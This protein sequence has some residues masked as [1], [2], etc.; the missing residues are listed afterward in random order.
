MAA[1]FLAEHVH[2]KGIAYIVMYT[3]FE[4]TVKPLYNEQSRDPTNCSLYGGVHPRELPRFSYSRFIFR[5]LSSAPAE[6]PNYSHSWVP[7]LPYDHLAINNPLIYMTRHCQCGNLSAPAVP[8]G[9]LGPWARQGMEIS[10]QVPVRIQS[11][12]AT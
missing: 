5:M 6:I 8:P 9:S 3:V 1:S 12:A 4:C 7:S 2:S 11:L 10:G